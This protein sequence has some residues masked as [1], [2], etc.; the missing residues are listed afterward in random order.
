MIRNLKEFGDLKSYNLPFAVFRPHRIDYDQLSVRYNDR[1][2]PTVRF[3]LHMNGKE[4]RVKE[5]FLDWFFQGFPKSLMSDFSSAFS[6]LSEF[7]L[8]DFFIF[9]GKNY[10]GR[11][12]A[13]AY[14]FGT[15]LEIESLHS[16]GTADFTAIFEDMLEGVSTPD[17]ISGMQFPDRS[18]FA[19]GNKG[20]WF[21]DERITRLKWTRS[22]NNEI[23]AIAGHELK[24]SGYGSI[25][26]NGKSSSIFILQEKNYLRSVWIEVT[27]QGIELDHA[28][29]RIRQGK[30]LFN[31]YIREDSKGLKLVMREPNGPAVFSILHDGKQFTVGI[32]P[33]FTRHFVDALISD[34]V[35]RSDIFINYCC[36]IQYYEGKG[37]TEPVADL[38]KDSP[39]LCT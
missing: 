20:D 25:V 9:T 5:F 6:P 12:A 4:F 15:Q 38:Q 33:G 3:I 29:Y 21:E 31:V 16:C 27:D 30:N 7:K 34:I 11:E 32:S 2:W 26:L 8:G 13:S 19:N 37:G 35:N 14:V 24:G 28:F 39:C 22:R 36:I 17:S 18:H 1:K 23:Y 10:R